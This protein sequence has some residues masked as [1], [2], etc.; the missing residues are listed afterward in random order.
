MLFLVLGFGLGGLSVL[1]KNRKYLL[2][3]PAIIKVI[4]ASIIVL[5]LIS[6]LNIETKFL[7]SMMFFSIL[8]YFVTSLKK[9]EE[10]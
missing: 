1:Y 2:R 6:P 8:M 9:K 7:L 10:N 5:T 4:C 3:I